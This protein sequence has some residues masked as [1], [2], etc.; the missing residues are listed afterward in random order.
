MNTSKLLLFFLLFFVG[1]NMAQTNA[2][3]FI[4]TDCDGNSHHLFSEL[5]NGK[6]IVI[7]WVMPCPPC[8]THAV[9]A[10]N[11]V[12][13]FESSHPDRVKYYLVDDFANTTCQALN[14]WANSYNIDN[15]IMFSDPAI[16]MTDYGQIGMPKIAV[17]GGT[18]HEIFFNKNSSTQGIDAAINQ[19]L[20]ATSVERFKNSMGLQ[21]FPN[22]SSQILNI[23]YSFNSSSV[24]HLEIFNMLGEKIDFP[25]INLNV[26]TGKIQLNVSSFNEGTYFLKLS[27]DNLSQVN[28]FN[29]IH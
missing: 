21:L 27:A 20:L 18:N 29:V 4:T 15:C 25:K 7:A 8:A 19:A 13:S 26:T 11:S 24:T 22:P 10:Y 9:N 17:V 1:S 12:I 23:N 3:D 6:V 2:T 28:K 16:S 5:D 14:N